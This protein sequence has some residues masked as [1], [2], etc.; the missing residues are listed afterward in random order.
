MKE[1]VVK[2][3]SFA[4]A[5]RVVKLVKYL[6]GEKAFVL[7]KYALDFLRHANIV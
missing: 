5:L 7:S 1:N 6:Q 2:Q 4:F 3:K